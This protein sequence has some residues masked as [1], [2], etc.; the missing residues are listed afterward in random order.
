MKKWYQFW[1]RERRYCVYYKFKNGFGSCVL[2]QTGG[3]FLNYEL[4]H[5]T[6]TE[7]SIKKDGIEIKGLVIVNYFRIEPFKNKI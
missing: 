4:T 7:L 3:K 6:I 1:V 5:K 2:T